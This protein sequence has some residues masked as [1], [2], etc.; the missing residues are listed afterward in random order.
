VIPGENGEGVRLIVN[1][2]Q[3][4]GPLATGSFCTGMASD[5]VA[6][7]PQVLWRPVIVGP[8]SF[9]L[10]DKLASCQFAYKEEN[11]MPQA[12]DVWRPRWIR[13]VTPAAV[14]FDMVPL[15]PDPARLQV[16]PVVAAL[17]PTRNP[18]IEVTED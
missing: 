17:R 9:V 12:P 13:D 15:H 10:A 6:G 8:N 4:T 1:E 18:L 7:V 5:P 11:P 3:Y 14:R 16:P 2:H